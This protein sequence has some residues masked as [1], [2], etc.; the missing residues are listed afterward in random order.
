MTRLAWLTDIHLDHLKPRLQVRQAFAEMVA[1]DSD[2]CAISGDIST[3]HD[4][5]LLGDFAKYYGKPV[6]FVLGNH[7][8][9]GGGFLTAKTQILTLQKE[10]A[11]L[12][13]LTWMTP[14]QI[15]PGVEICGV[16]GWYDAEFGSWRD[17]SFEM[18]DWNAIYDFWG[19]RKL[20]VVMK[21]R[22]RARD[23]AA[24]AD[25]Q[26]EQTTSKKVFF[27]THVPPYEQAACHLGQ[28]SS[29]ISVPWY[30]NKILGLVL[31]KWAKANPDSELVTLCG[32]THSAAE[33]QRADNHLVLAG[34]AEYGAPTI[35]KVFEL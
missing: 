1:T 31:D 32:H 9:W 19:M 23:Q 12:H 24:L 28:P 35:Q 29:R 8:I 33:Y 17:S 22:E 3:W 26:L 15:A 2:C 11:N 14:V 10:Y 13:W 7:D 16:D 4:A 5:R 20:D 27:V 21:S 30:T 25:I 18:V 34:A 6:Y